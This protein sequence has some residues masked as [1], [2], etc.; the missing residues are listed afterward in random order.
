MPSK[1]TCYGCVCCGSV[2]FLALLGMLIASFIYIEY[3][4]LALKKNTLTNTVDKSEAYDV[5]V[6]VWG[7][8]HTKVSF[9]A[10]FQLVQLSLDVSNEQGVSLDIDVSFWYQLQK[11]TLAETY[12]KYG[13]RYETQIKSIARA[14]VRNVA[15]TFKVDA[16]LANRS[17]ITDAIASN[18]SQ[19]LAES[20]FVY[21]PEA[22]VQLNKVSFTESIMATHLN[23]AVRLEENEKKEFE[24]QAALIRRETDKLVQIYTANTTII[25]RTAQADKTAKIRSARAEYEEIVGQARGV[26]MSNAID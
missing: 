1:L 15:V 3:D 7:F 10:L 22:S 11:S 4:E 25:T 18:I 2:T 20:V 23:A 17:V 13:L 12:T 5:G 16:F 9:P 14:V 26:G 19:K 8:D 24:Q 6:Y 21:V